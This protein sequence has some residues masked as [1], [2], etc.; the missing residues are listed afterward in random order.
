MPPAGAAGAVREDVAVSTPPPVCSLV[1]DYG[2]RGGFVGAL[3]AVIDHLAPGTVVIDLD[4]EIPRHDVLLGALRIERS[5][6]Y[7]RPCV[8]VGVVD[9][10]VG[11]ARRAVAA[12]AGGHLFVGPDNGLLAC[13]LDRLG[14]EVRAVVL[15]DERWF[16]PAR[17]RTFD[18]RDLFAPVGAHLATGVPLERLGTEIDPATLVRLERPRATTLADGGLELPVIQVDGFGNVQFP[19]AAEPLPDGVYELE[20]AS[21]AGRRSARA[22]AGQTFADVAVGE[23]VLLVDSDGCLALSVNQGRADELL[24]L[25]PGDRVVCH[26]LS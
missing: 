10:G 25:A 16:W 17:A 4:H 26:R 1:T 8:H 15:D 3:H 21:A 23:A 9:P 13:A 5:L 12:A 7:L 14:G 19:E 6:A 18:G 22:Q 20:H 24:Q 11:G 2:W